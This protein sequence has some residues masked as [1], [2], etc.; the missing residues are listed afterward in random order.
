M[1]LKIN[2]CGDSFCATKSKY[3][4]CNIL[5]KKLNAEII[6]LG[7]SGSAHEH[8]IKSFNSKADI[9]IFCWTDANRIYHEKYILT[10]NHVN[11]QLL[12]PN[13]LK[14]YQA[15]KVYWQYVHDGSYLQERQN[16]DLYWFDHEI[17]SQY[18]GIII[19]F[20]CHPHIK[21]YKFTNGY[22]HNK[23]LMK[24]FKTKDTDYIEYF[25]HFS[26]EN[27]KNLAQLTFN[28]LQKF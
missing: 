15:I 1:T 5:S 11:K 18:K 9:T 17:L 23:S 13:P 28:L 3:A 21:R 4:W 25:N 6:G 22:M 24:M 20:Y 8:A 14:I 12:K 19:H 7:K 16:R 27:N 2:F 26:I 10:Y